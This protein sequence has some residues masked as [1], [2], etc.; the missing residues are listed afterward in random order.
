[1]IVVNMEE[2]KQEEEEESYN[3]RFLVFL[4]ALVK[5]QNGLTVFGFGEAHLCNDVCEVHTTENGSTWMVQTTGTC[6]FPI[7][8]LK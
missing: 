3:L 8:G 4:P 5:L 7:K 6:L 2:K 1:M